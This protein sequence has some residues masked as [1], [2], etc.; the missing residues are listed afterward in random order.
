LFALFMLGDLNS[1][2][3][4]ID[5]AQGLVRRLGAWRFEQ[6]CLVYVAKIAHAEGR[7]G[8]AVGGLAPA[9]GVAPRTGPGVTGPMIQSALAV[10]LTAPNRRRRALAEFEALLARGSIGHN[11]LRAFPDA[12]DVALELS[13]WDEA[14]RYASQLEAYTRVEPL[15]WSD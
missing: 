10:A 8:E 6:P 13:D 3:A 4:E 11:Q 2:R 12:I 9:D 7:R 1:C 5:K 15:P 14:Q